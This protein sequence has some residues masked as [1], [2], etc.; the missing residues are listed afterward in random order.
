MI[1][2]SPRGTKIL[3]NPTD[4]ISIDRDRSVAGLLEK[5][6]SISFQGRNLATAH[7]L[8]LSMLSDNCTVFMGMAGALVA[9]GMRK[10]VA[11]LIKNRYIDV[12]VTTGANVFADLH[13]TLGRHHY[14]GSP[15]YDDLELRDMQVERIYDTLGSEVEFREADEWVGSFT[16]TLDQSRPYS[17]REFFFLL[18]RELSEISNEEGILTDTSSTST[19]T[20][21]YSEFAF[22]GFGDGQTHNLYIGHVGTLIFR[23]NYS[24]HA[25]IGHLL[26]SRAAQ[27][28]ILYNRLSDEATG[29]ASYQ[30]DLPNGGKSYVIGN[31]IEQGPANDNN[32]LVAYMEEG[33][34]PANPNHQLF[35]VNNT[36]RN[37]AGSGTFVSVAAG[38]DAATITN[39]IFSGPGTLTNQTTAIKANNFAG[40]PSF[41]N[42]G[43]Y[44]FHL[45]SGSPAINAGT[46]PGADG[47]FSLLPVFQYVH[48]ACAEGRNSVGTIDIGAYEFGG[49]TGTPPS[50]ALCTP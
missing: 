40:D 17:T 41:V 23:Y 20:I 21:E 49:G 22:N 16:N 48:P 37:D 30:I 32:T 13:E 14:I 1:K 26:K 42:A 34:D 50:G 8:W 18:G 24:H 29:T 33:T 6:E 46:N 39:N 28:L 4:P 31:V 10:V 15:D 25:I 11:H 19:V 45:N 3:R 47:T 9:G 35:V 2:K 5:M 44:D 7:Q 36:F 43:S 38:A 27:N 12:L